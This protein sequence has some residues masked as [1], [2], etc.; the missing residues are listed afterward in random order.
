L[1]RGEDHNAFI[2][3][4]LP[5]EP[6][7]IRNH[8][9]HRLVAV[10]GVPGHF[11]PANII[12]HQDVIL[13]PAMVDRQVILDGFPIVHLLAVQQARKIAPRFDV[14]EQSEHVSMIFYVQLACGH[15]ILPMLQGRQTEVVIS[16]TLV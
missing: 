13:I 12:H 7:S 5:G 15:T 8:S 14:L 3:I 16:M 9:S 4:K 11:Q 1:N 6:L 2:L 10:F